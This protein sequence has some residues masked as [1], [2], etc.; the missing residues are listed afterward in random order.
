V[1]DGLLPDVPADGVGDPGLELA[2]R[3]VTNTFG[4]FRNRHVN[5][6]GSE[7]TTDE[8]CGFRHPVDGVVW[9]SRI[10]NPIEE[11]IQTFMRYDD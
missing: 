9:H 7:A 2:T 1:R 6:A 5:F 10:A 3:H 4:N 8:S 11:K